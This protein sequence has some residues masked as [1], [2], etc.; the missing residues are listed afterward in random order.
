MKRVVIGSFLVSAF[1]TGILAYPKLS[2]AGTF[3]ARHSHSEC[4]TVA[5][6]ADSFIAGGNELTGATMILQCRTHDTAAQP[7]VNVAWVN[8]HVEDNSPSGQIQAA[9]CVR[10]ASVP[11]G[12]CGTYAKTSASG[13]GLQLLNPLTFSDWTGAD[14]GYIEVLLPPRSSSGVSSKLKGYSM[15]D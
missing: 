13:T 7:R 11:S 10:Y 14:F 4:N 5:G 12:N 1:A 3:W 15:G 6:G 8:M 9:R 2:N